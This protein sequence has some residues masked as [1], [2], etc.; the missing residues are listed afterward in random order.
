MKVLFITSW[1]P[2]KSNPVTGI[3]I[4]EHAKAVSLYNEVV[5]IFNEDFDYSIKKVFTIS[6][7]KEEGIRTIRIKHRLPH[8]P[9]TGYIIYVIGILL[10]CRKLL[11]E[12][13]PDIIHAHIYSAGVPAI[14]LS[15]IYRIPV[16]VSE[17]W[18]GYGR[19]ILPL[20][21]RIKARFALNRASAVITV[22][23]DLQKTLEQYGIRNKFYIVPN[24]VNTEI[25]YP[26]PQQIKNPKKRMLL[27]AV[28]TP[29][30]G[31]P[32]LL[33]ALS[34]L[35]QERQDFVLDIVGDGSHRKEY[36]ELTGKL[37][38][39]E[40]VRFHGMKSKEEVAE[41]M[42]KCVFLFSQVYT[43]LLV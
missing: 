8:I 32:Y 21:E 41:F 2:L 42:R 40:I 9:K 19:G 5:V 15:V 11:K 12:W 37:G 13:H 25:F 27:V 36:E 1:Y 4:K 16:V 35:K 31:I 29:I 38:L 26:S 14:I 34:E 18:T 28:L 17:H 3:F 30:K 20:F 10:A 7:N 22:S 6:D 39:K 23:Q 33:N 24:V 43:R